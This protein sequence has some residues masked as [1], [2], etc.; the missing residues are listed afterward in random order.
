MSNIFFTS[1]MHFGH[2]NVIK[3]CNRPYSSVEDMDNQLIANWNSI[4]S[5]NDKV[6]HVGDFAFYP[7][8]KIGDIIKQLHGTILFVP[9]NHDKNLV[10][11]LISKDLSG[12]VALLDSIH[13]ETFKVD[14][15]KIPFV[16]CHYAMRVWDKA[17]YGAIHLYGHSHGSLP[18][19]PTSRSMDV[20][21]DT[22]NWKPY[23]MQ[24]ILVRMYQKV[25]KP[26][27]HH[28]T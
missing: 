8:D 22:N 5:R 23:S 6:Y 21:A 10:K 28:G 3:Y 2:T 17:H 27:D 18:D 13:A 19:D 9:G 25:Y 26:V 7:Q 11:Y 12:K 14:G 16:L 1:D 4:V 15:E 24:D 20:G